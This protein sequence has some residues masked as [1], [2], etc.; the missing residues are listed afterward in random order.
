M[1][2]MKKQ[3]IISIILATLL[4]IAMVYIGNSEYLR[5]K[6]V[7]Q[8]GI[9]QQGAQDG[10]SQAIIQI[11]EQAVTCEQIPLTIGNQTI[12]LIAV[13]CLKQ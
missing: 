1:K 13:D 10:Y 4:I 2:D 6:G 3:T 9:Y 7:E 12:N 11:V 8:A 5:K